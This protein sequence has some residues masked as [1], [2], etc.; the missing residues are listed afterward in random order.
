MADCMSHHFSLSIHFLG[1][2]PRQACGAQTL[3]PRGRSQTLRC[4]KPLARS[5]GGTPAA[6]WIDFPSE[7]KIGI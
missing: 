1:I 2:L 3:P 7:M 4:G 5:S 6:S